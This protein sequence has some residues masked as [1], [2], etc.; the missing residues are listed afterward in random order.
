MKWSLIKRT[1]PKGTDADIWCDW[2]NG[3]AERL[4][5]CYVGED[6]E[7]HLPGGGKIGQ[8]ENITHFMIVTPPNPESQP[9][10]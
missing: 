1:P 2:D 5:N 9:P 8:Q 7:W 3:R 10:A 6:C 4:T